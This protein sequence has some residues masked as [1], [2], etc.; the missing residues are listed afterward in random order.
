MF[1]IKTKKSTRVFALICSFVILFTFFTS[2]ISAVDVG[3]SGSE[4]GELTHTAAA[5][6]PVVFNHLFN[7]VSGVG[8][9]VVPFSF[10]IAPTAY[11]YTGVPDYSVSGLSGLFYLNSEPSPLLRVDGTY[12]PDMFDLRYQSTNSFA[13]FVGYSSHSYQFN[14]VYS[15]IAA[16]TVTLA[17]MTIDVSDFYCWNSDSYGDFTNGLH[18]EVSFDL[19]Y[20]EDSPFV[21]S[22]D[23][24]YRVIGSD[25]VV[26][27]SSIVE[28]EA[29]GFDFDISPELFGVTDPYAVVFV[30]SL[31]V[32]FSIPDTTPTYGS[33]FDL[34]YC[35]NPFVFNVVPDAPDNPAFALR[36]YTEWIATAVGGFFDLQIFPGFSLGGIFMTLVSFMCVVWFLKLVA[37]G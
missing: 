5:P 34:H 36:P 27:Y 24:V 11:T 33:I 18:S 22:F 32:N 15:P 23:V 6:V 26:S 10:S 31:T 13:G 17:D 1:K 35:Y 2:S 25:E 9:E 37:G 21:D 20:N 28:Y 14:S 8:I 4:N 16:Y 3:L 7:V 29:S 12:D 19:S 30:Y